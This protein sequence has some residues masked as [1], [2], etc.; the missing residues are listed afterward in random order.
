LLNQNNENFLKRYSSILA[1]LFLG[2]TTIYSGEDINEL[3][4]ELHSVVEKGDVKTVQELIKRGAD[5]NHQIRVKNEKGE[6][7]SPTI[8][9]IAIRMGYNDLAKFLLENHADVNLTDNQGETALCWAV[10]SG[11]SNNDVIK[12]LLSAKANVRV[13][14]SSIG[15]N[16]YPMADQG[17]LIAALVRYKVEIIDDLIKAGADVNDTDEIGSTPLMWAAERQQLDMVKTLVQK[18]ADVNVESKFKWTALMSAA[19]RNWPEGVEFLLSKGANPNVKTSYGHPGLGYCLT[20]SHAPWMKERTPLMEINNHYEFL[21]RKLAPGDTKSDEELQMEKEGKER[22]RKI[23]EM[24]K[25]A[26]AKE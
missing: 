26:G 12:K 10:S 18:G 13:K 22:N 21:D 6:T 1:V 24:L 7:K 9:M 3:N 17:V 15:S 16:H 8:L 2:L 23:A 19:A 25:K 4:L 11:V 20:H 5:I 14:T